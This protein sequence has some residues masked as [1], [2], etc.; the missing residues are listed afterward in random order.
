MTTLDDILSSHRTRRPVVMGILNVTPDSF[1]D[2]GRFFDSAA[3]VEHARLLVREGADVLDV[4][5]ES[6]RPG[7]GGVGPDEQIRRLAGVLPA[8][9]DLGRPVSID[10]TSAAVAAFALDAGAVIV[11]DVSAGRADHDLLPLAADRGA[12]VVLMHMLGT[13]RDMQ[14]DP[15]YDDVVAEVREFLA[16]RMDAAVAA[17]VPAGRIILDPGIGFGKTLEH[18]LALLAGTGRLVSLG[19]PV[20]VGPSRKRFLG[21]L[22]GQDQP[23]QRVVATAAACLAAWARG[24]SVFR[25]HDVSALVQALAVWRAVD[26]VAG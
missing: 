23:E 10:T 1:S 5:A 22:T 26:G 3:A 11:N 17:G 7:S 18:N 14:I 2:G 13:P 12:A 15:R 6:T 19:R 9:V 25:V 20:L 21:A 16:R 24:A 8:V 4:G